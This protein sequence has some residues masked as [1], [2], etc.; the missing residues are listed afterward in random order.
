MGFGIGASAVATVLAQYIGA[1]VYVTRIARAVR[2][3]SRVRAVRTVRRCARWRGR[4][5]RCSFAPL[6]CAG[7]LTMATAVAAHIGP[8][9]VAAHAIAFELWN[10]LAL[11]LDAIAIAA[12]AIVGKELGA[13]DADGGAWP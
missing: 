10:F 2:C 13:G 12:Q 3:A 1:A 5:V 11:A 7:S 9:E 6:R 4:A 8:V